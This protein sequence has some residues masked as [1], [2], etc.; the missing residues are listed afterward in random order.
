M[1]VKGLKSIITLK[2]KPI[3]IK[4]KQNW[5]Y[6]GVANSA[7]GSNQIENGGALNRLYYPGVA[8]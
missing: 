4:S 7:E 5:D 8:E 3:D 1:V 6:Y 2:I